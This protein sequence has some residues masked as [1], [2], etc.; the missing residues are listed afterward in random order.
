M[1]FHPCTVL[2]ITSN[3]DLSVDSVSV[4]LLML[5]HANS[6]AHMYI[7]QWNHLH[8][9]HLFWSRERYPPHSP[10]DGLHPPHLS[11]L[12]ACGFK[13]AQAEIRGGLGMKAAVSQR[14]TMPVLGGML[15]Q[16]DSLTNLPAQ[17]LQWLPL[18]WKMELVSHVMIILKSSLTGSLVSILWQTLMATSFSSRLPHVLVSHIP[19]RHTE[20][21]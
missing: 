18:S 5:T 19:L 16:R 1:D 21:V 14:Q 4:M 11:L 9:T 13:P 10:S 2:T 8:Q 6:C 3:P 20:N 7:V 17:S 15:V 12:P